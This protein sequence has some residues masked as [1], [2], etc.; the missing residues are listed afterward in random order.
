MT[1]REEDILS[2]EALIK[3]GVVLDRLIQSIVLNTNVD[4]S[5]ILVCDRNAILIAARKNAYGQDYEASTLCPACNHKNE[6]NYDLD[7][8]S[9]HDHQLPIGVSV[10]ERGTLKVLLPRSN[11]LVEFRLLFGRDETQ[12]LKTDKNRINNNQVSEQLKN[13][14]LSVDAD[15]N[16][17]LVQM[18]CENMPAYDSRFLRS[19]IKQSTPSTS[20][21]FDLT[22]QACGNQTEVEVPI[23]IKFFWPDA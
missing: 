8:F 5:S 12:A 10:T 6:I 11:K 19:I 16:A 21:M 13:V 14:V 22:C 3:S 2:S 15:D 1:A 7:N 23:G 4:P 9:V 18:F 20:L 17:G